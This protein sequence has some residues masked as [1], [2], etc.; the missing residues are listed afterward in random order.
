MNT[1]KD[2]AKESYISWGVIAGK[3]D[4]N[5][6]ELETNVEGVS[7]T[8]K[9]LDLTAY[10]NADAS[11][12]QELV[13]YVDNAIKDIDIP[14]VPSLDE[15][16]K[17]EDIPEVPSLEGYAKK[18]DI[19]SLDGYLRADEVGNIQLEGYA[20]IEDIPSVDGFVK[21]EDLFNNVAMDSDIESIFNK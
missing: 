21:A 17:I 9:N 11:L 13:K 15:Y 5:F 2:I 18:E 10:K 8:I 16:A 7:G 20:K 14:E 6:K 1:I 4:N 19:P 3:I 12:K